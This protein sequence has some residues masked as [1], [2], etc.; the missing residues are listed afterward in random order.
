MNFPVGN[1]THASS[2]LSIFRKIYF[3]D[4]GQK[5]EIRGIS[6]R[7]SCSRI[8]TCYSLTLHSLHCLNDTPLCIV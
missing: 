3:C 8:K 2:K 4:P 6:F 5:C 1:F 7:D